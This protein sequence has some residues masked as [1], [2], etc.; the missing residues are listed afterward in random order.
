M[1]E[2]VEIFTEPDTLAALISAMDAIGLGYLTLGQSRTT[3]SGG[4]AQRIKLA[5]AAL[6]GRRDDAPGLIILDEPVTGLHPQDA[7]RLMGALDLLLERGNTI[8][9]AEHDIHAAA[10]TDW[11]IDLGPGSG[12]TGGRIINTGTP[13]HVA[14]GPG[15]TAPHLQRLQPH[16]NRRAP[17][18]QEVPMS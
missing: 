16:G 10:S 2:A 11:I 12:E 18:S 15:P 13:A 3:L 6:R 14:T 4:E 1:A 9:I 7:Q 8:V 5:R 17:V